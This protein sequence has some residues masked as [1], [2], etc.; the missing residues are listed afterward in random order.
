MPYSRPEVT[1]GVTRITKP[2][3]ENILDGIDEK[4]DE[5]TANSTY[6]TPASVTTAVT[7]KA[8]SV[9]MSALAFAASRKVAWAG[10]STITGSGSTSNSTKGVSALTPQFA[11]SSRI[12]RYS[13]SIMAGVDGNTSAQL[14]ARYD[15]DVLNQNPGIVVLNIG[16]NDAS[17]A[18]PIA[19]YAANVTEIVD[20]TLKANVPIVLTTVTPRR[21]D[22]SGASAI[23]LLNLWLT[24]F[25]QRRNLP[26]VDLF[27]ALSDPATGFFS[28]TYQAADGTHA[29]DAGHALMA[30]LIGAKLRELIPLPVWLPAQGVSPINMLANPLVTG[31]L[32]SGLPAG[33]FAGVGDASGSVQTTEDPIVGDGLPAGRWAAMS[34]DNSAGGAAVYKWLRTGYVTSGISQGDV[35]RMYC[36]VKFTGS[37]GSCGLRLNSGS[38]TLASAVSTFST[39]TP[40]PIIFDVTAPASPTQINLAL[41]VKAEAATTVK[42]FIGCAGIFNLTTNSLV[43]LI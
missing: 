10:S 2:F 7:P 15:A 20:R 31:T 23:P 32:T 41:F 35:L 11:G 40:A 26:I 17:Q 19:T 38:T 12:T 21:A 25:A 6:A 22:V 5:A 28:A 34:I 33:W 39:D 29:N 3:V 18:V 37:Y 30:S 14:L 24:S 1:S 9:K 43:G 36:H 42:G 13:E 8:S 27:K 16:G 4:L